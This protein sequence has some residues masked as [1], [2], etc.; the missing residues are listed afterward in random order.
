MNHPSFTFHGIRE[1]M[2]V[3]LRH[4]KEDMILVKTAAS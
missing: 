4:V 2:I 3:I 1:C